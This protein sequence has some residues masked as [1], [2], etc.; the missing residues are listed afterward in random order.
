MLED[1]DNSDTRRSDDM[2]MLDDCY[3]NRGSASG[4]AMDVETKLPHR[5]NA[6]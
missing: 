4:E 2:E 1:S 6:D 3:G 5:R